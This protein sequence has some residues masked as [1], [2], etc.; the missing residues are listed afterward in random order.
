MYSQR[1]SN[2]ITT[3]LTSRLQVSSG[4]AV[5]RHD[6]LTSHA[7][8]R[9]ILPLQVIDNAPHNRN[10]E[11]LRCN[12]IRSLIISKIVYSLYYTWIYFFNNRELLCH[13]ILSNLAI[14]KTVCL[15]TIQ[16]CHLNVIII[17][18]II[19]FSDGIK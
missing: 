12:C 10:R 18:L 6:K 11:L 13:I 14:P 9:S 5:R 19:V 15:H 4:I 3:L 8:S 1:L 16:T 17:C 2:P 7:F